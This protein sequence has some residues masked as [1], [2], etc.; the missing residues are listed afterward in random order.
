MNDDINSLRPP[1]SLAELGIETY[2]RNF[3][4]RYVSAY[5]RD[6]RPTDSIL[7]PDNF[8][9]AFRLPVEGKTVAIVG[10]GKVNGYGENIDAHD[11]V[12]RLNYPYNWKQDPAEDGVR[13]THWMGLGK[14]EVFHPSEFHNPHE[15][16]K[17]VD[18]GERITEVES[19]HCISHQHVEAR[20][21]HEIQK[22]NLRHKFFVHWAAPVVF[23][24]IEQTKFGTD[25]SFLTLIT[26]RAY[27]ENG[28]G[29]WYTWEILFTG[30]RAML[31]AA[32]SNPKKISIFG[33][34]FFTDGDRKPWDMHKEN[35]NLEA[36]RKIIW[37]ARHIGIEVVENKQQ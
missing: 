1:L 14:F 10:N 11:V 22:R 37:L 9:S 12:V 3:G 32:M 21:W 29:G 33:M 36:Y 17:A 34:N 24:E 8:Y 13:F 19:L 30:V 27:L 28:Y 26:S 4:S 7:F 25:Q 15:E 5:A 31:L 2:R 35:L 16:F 20:F 18:L 6:K 23:N